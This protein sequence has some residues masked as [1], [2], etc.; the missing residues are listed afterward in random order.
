MPSKVVGWTQKYICILV[1]ILVN[2]TSGIDRE[3]KQ[4][5]CDIL[6]REWSLGW[7]GAGDLF[8]GQLS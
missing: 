4:G 8:V 1:Q 3:A 6:N 7:A 5:L 2:S